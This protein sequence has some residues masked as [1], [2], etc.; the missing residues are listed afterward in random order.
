MACSTQLALNASGSV[1]SNRLADS[2]TLAVIAPLAWADNSTASNAPLASIVTCCSR[3]STCPFTFS[4]ISK[5]KCSARV[6]FI[7]PFNSPC[8]CTNT[9]SSASTSDCL[10]LASSMENSGIFCVLFPSVY[11]VSSSNTVPIFIGIG[12]A[13]SGSWGT[14]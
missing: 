13:I 8:S 2:V 9:S 3:L 14:V 6:A 11:A 10:K 1:S 7:W 12:D 5:G 4:F